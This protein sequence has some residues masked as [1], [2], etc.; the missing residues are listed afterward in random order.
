M[1]PGDSEQAG[2][3]PIADLPADYITYQATGKIKM[4]LGN[5]SANDIR[6]LSEPTNAEPSATGNSGVVGLWAWLR[7]VRT[8]KTVCVINGGISGTRSGAWLPGSANYNAMLAKARVALLHPLTHLAGY[9]SFNGL[10]DALDPPGAGAIWS[11]NT[12]SMFD[13]LA[14]DLGVAPIYLVRYPADVPIGSFPSHAEV[15]AA[16]AAAPFAS[17]VVDAPEGPWIEN[18]GHVHLAT[19]G[20]LGA[21]VALDAVIP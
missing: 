13:G 19:A 7:S 6:N 9:V 21:A 20:N 14:A 16:I 12:D 15:R 8:G 5:S 18:P 3:G 17:G 11:A 1:C 10:N 2:R 4:V